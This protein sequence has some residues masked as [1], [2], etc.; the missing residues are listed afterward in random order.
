MSYFD[1]RGCGEQ[2]CT[3]GDGT[4]LCF[5]HHGN[6]ILHGPLHMCGAGAPVI[7]C[8][9]CHVCNNRCFSFIRFHKT[10]ILTF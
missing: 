8:V 6:V 4:V 10:C 1:I 2:W 5:I 9:L 7:S 3:P